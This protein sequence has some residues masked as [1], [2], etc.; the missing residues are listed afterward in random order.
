MKIDWKA[1]LSSRK[2]WVA[3]AGILSGIALMITSD[4]NTAQMVSGAVT[5]I[6][7]I[8]I[9]VYGESKVDAN[10]GN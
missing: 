6:S 5:E 4:E 7:S 2:F 8:V 9:Y 10:R 3:L 1:K